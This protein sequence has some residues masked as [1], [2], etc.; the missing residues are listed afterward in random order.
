MLED[1]LDAL[2]RKSPLVQLSAFVMN[3]LSAGARLVRSGDEVALWSL[4]IVDDPLR[5]LQD[6]DSG[7]WLGS[8]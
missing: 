4:G 1:T 2:F 7:Q 8:S 3:G 6:L 5:F